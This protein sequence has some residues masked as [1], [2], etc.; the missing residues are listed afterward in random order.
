MQNQNVIYFVT[1]TIK[2]LKLLS[3]IYQVCLKFY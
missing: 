2:K 3:D 1:N